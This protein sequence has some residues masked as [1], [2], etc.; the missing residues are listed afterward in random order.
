MPL[1]ITAAKT[2]HPYVAVPWLGAMLGAWLAHAMFD[3]TVL[4][5]TGAVYGF[6]ASTSWW[7]SWSARPS[8]PPC[9]AR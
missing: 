2:A 6:T 3:M 7:P 4:Q 5:F 9:T 1:S 8:Q